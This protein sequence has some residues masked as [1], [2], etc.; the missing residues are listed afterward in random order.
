METMRPL[1]SLLVLPLLA[2]ACRSGGSGPSTPSDAGADASPSNPSDTAAGSD[3][4]NPVDGSAGTDAASDAAHPVAGSEAKQHFELNPIHEVDLLF[5]V[6]N[7]PG[8]ASRQK[9]LAR[10]LPVLFQELGKGPAGLPDLQV[11]VVSTDLGA[12]SRP[13]SNGVCPRPGGDRGI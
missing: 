1:R 8:M 10:N 2:S 4:A 11:G 6:A 13:L 9:E 7:T 5:V 3:S 12:G